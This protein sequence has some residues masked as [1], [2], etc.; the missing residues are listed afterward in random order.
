MS[1]ADYRTVNPA[2]EDLSKFVETRAVAVLTEL[3]LKGGAGK[4][5]LGYYYVNNL[6]WPIYAAVQ[7]KGLTVNDQSKI[8][9][10]VKEVL[11]EKKLIGGRRRRRVT[12]KRLSRKRMTRRR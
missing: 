2:V 7:K 8:D 10:T 1:G 11:T 4:S 12:R 9:D 6:G 3:G 5:A